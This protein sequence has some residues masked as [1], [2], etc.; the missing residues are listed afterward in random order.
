VPEISEAHAP[1]VD[2]VEDELLLLAAH[3]GADAADGAWVRRLV[4]ANPDWAQILWIAHRHGTLPLL[5]GLLRASD[6][7]GVPGRVLEQL[8]AHTLA[9]G[10]RQA[11]ARDEAGRAVDALEDASVHTLTLRT[12]FVTTLYAEP[13]RRELEPVELLVR[14]ADA[15]RAAAR[16]AEHGYA[17]VHDLTPAR[18]RALRRARAAA[19]LQHRDRGVR[20][21]L[22]DRVTPSFFPLRLDADELWRGRTTFDGLPRLSPEHMLLL[23]CAHGAF[24][25]WHRL[26]WVADLARL[27]ERVDPD[28]LPRAAAI[29]ERADASRIL[30]LGLTLAADLFGA[31][32]AGAGAPASSPP[33]SRPAIDPSV[34]TLARQVR[35]R[36][37]HDRYGRTSELERTR[38]RLALRDRPAD[39][40]R[41]AL[42]FAL[43]PTVEDWSA[44]PLPDALFPLYHVVRPAR[45]AATIAGATGSGSR[46]PFFSTS[47]PVVERMLAVADL[48]PGD[49]LYDL[50]CGDG[51]IV[52]EA[53]RRYGARGVGVDL[54]PARIAESAANARD[55]GVAHLVRFVQ[56]DAG[57]VD[58]AGADVVTLW[59]LPTLN[60]RLR[61]KLRRE[62]RPGA[63]VVGHSFDMG[64]WAPSQTDL[65]PDESSTIAVYRWTVG[66]QAAAATPVSVPAPA[67]PTP[68][69]AMAS[70]E[71]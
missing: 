1:P 8:A 67:V 17:P 13:A 23:F 65:V 18:A 22:H 40:L 41:Y 3:P 46:A 15:D 59:T 36:L 34:A 51:R 37:L 6:A 52:I 70:P 35:H 28:S 10:R 68:V 5:D 20:I 47:L 55:A 26:V 38:F 25:L 66:A 31:A 53:A 62:L 56:A 30:Q 48:G 24:H 69:G 71:T 61:A 14:P 11:A 16:L 9:N 19:I 45:L 4:L 58:L 49:T 29:A 63:C 57:E 12:P 33:A 64:D 43:A 42:G 54:D 27:V 2:S 50:G 32:P 44:V 60:L 39:R 21:H 7:Q